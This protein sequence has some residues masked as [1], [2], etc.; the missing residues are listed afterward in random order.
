MVYG[1]VPARHGSVLEYSEVSW[2]CS[3]GV[4]GYSGSVPGSVRF[5]APSCFYRHPSVLKAFSFFIAAKKTLVSLVVSE[6]PRPEWLHVCS[7][8]MAVN[9]MISWF[10][11]TPEL[12]AGLQNT[13]QC[14]CS[15]WKTLENQS[16]KLEA[17]SCLKGI[18][19]KHCF[20]Q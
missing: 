10:V 12:S 14:I 6:M 17:N 7:V 8:F 20:F 1:G 16:A 18:L 5:R 2:A 15:D 11:L 13:P 9:I 3:A 4:P 19:P